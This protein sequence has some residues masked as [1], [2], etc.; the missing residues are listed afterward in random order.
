M[1]I[2]RLLTRGGQ[3]FAAEVVDGTETYKVFLEAL[4]STVI[5]PELIKSGWQLVALPLKLVKNGIPLEKLPK[6]EYSPSIEEEQ[7]MYDM[8][9]DEMPM[10]ERK[11]LISRDNVQTVE[12]SEGVYT[13]Q[14]REEFLSYLEQT[15]KIHL[16]EDFLPI[17]YFVHP[18]ALFTWAEYKDPDNREWVAKLERRRHLTLAQFDN[19]RAWAVQHGLKSDYTAM[20]L[21]S[22]YFQWGICGLNAQ[23]LSR[24]TVDSASRRELR[25]GIGDARKLYTYDYGLIDRYQREYRKPGTERYKPVDSQ[26]AVRISTLLQGK[27]V[28]PIRLQQVAIEQV[29]EWETPEGS[30]CF[31]P[32]YLLVGGTSYAPLS[33]QGKHGTIAPHFWNP[34]SEPAMNEDMYLHALAEEFIDRRLVRCDVSSY[35]ALCESGCSPLSALLYMRDVMGLEN[36]DPANLEELV[37][38]STADI[39]NYL[40]GEQVADGV[41]ETLEDMRLGATNID[42]VQGGIR[43]DSSQTADKIYAMFYCAHHIFHIP[44]EDI[45]KKVVEFDG[46]TEVTF[47]DGE[48]VLRVPSAPIDLA[49]KGFL[50]DKADYRREAVES[51]NCYLWVDRVAREMGPAD[52]SRHVGVLCYYASNTG[53]TSSHIAGLMEVFQAKVKEKVTDPRAQEA[54]NKYAKLFAV[55]AFFTGAMQGFYQFPEELDKDVVFL[56]SEERAAYRDC[57]TGP[58]VEDTV[59]IADEAIYPGYP[60]EWKWYCVNAVVQPTKVTPRFGFTV[61]ETNLLAVWYNLTSHPRYREF[62][63][64]R[65]LDPGDTCWSTL[66]ATNP[67]FRQGRNPAL[68]LSNYVEQAQ[69]ALEDYDHARKFTGVPHLLETAYPTLAP[70]DNESY[71]PAGLNEQYVF[72]LGEAHVLRHQKEEEPV[73]ITEHPPIHKFLGLSA[74]DFFYTGGEFTLPVRV[75]KKPISVLGDLFVDGHVIRPADVEKLDSTQYPVSH[76]CGR[77]YLVCDVVGDYWVVEV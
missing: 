15:D 74:E 43:S 59:S 61:R 71:A 29:E 64:R 58:C 3:P 44:L 77:R 41:R 68:G 8:L 13:I 9:H 33:A 63:K 6:M 69:Q 18:T 19:F 75:G 53:R 47:T 2:K 21:T 5:L 76:L 57:I 22:F 32:R 38:I 46:H 72:Q 65:L 49:Y 30:I 56:S 4:G 55:N 31:N 27:E 26:E 28:T 60:R 40:K 42:A 37:P 1:D 54:M 73:R 20:D 62:V 36:V 52:A 35:R 70:D 50:S 14:T 45:Y 67:L 25:A 11:K 39:I 24:H 66:S 16:A 23:V 7:D 48:H 51:A 10:D 12:L 34:S 17:N